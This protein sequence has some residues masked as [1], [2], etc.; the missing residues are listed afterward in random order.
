M[1]LVQL[2]RALAIH[3]PDVWIKEGSLFSNDHCESLWTGEGS[4]II[5]DGLE[6]EAF[7]MYPFFPA[8]YE[9]GVLQ[10]LADFLRERGFYAEA[11]DPGTY[12]IWKA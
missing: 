7:D 11:H 4:K 5:R 12:F 1:N 3:F 9:F 10:E 8:L 6:L 2:Q